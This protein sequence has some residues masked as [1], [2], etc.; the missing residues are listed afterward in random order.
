MVAE[1]AGIEGYSFIHPLKEAGG[2]TSWC[3]L[4]QLDGRKVLLKAILP[5]LPDRLGLQIRSHRSARSMASKT[6]QLL[7]VRCSRTRSQGSLA[8]G[9]SHRSC[10]GVSSASQLLARIQASE[11][12]WPS[13]RRK[14]R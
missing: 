13:R 10:Q 14:Q 3:C 2:V 11:S 5:N 1:F 9:A 6:R 4:R 7:P 8:R 12:P